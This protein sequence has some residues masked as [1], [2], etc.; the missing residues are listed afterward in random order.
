MVTTNGL[1]HANGTCRDFYRNE[2]STF[3]PT[4]KVVD[5]TIRDGGLMNKWQFSDELVRDL[6]HANVAAGVDYMEIGYLTS[7]SYFKRGD[8]GAWRFCADAD[9]RRIMGNNDTKMKIAAMAD[10]GRV[11]DCDI[12]QKSDCLLDLI[13]VA[14]YD[15]QIDEAIRLA[16]LCVDRGY[17]VSINL[18]AVAKNSLEAIDAC[19]DKVAAECK[20]NYFYIADSFGS[21]YGEQ[22]RLLARRYLR[23]LGPG[24]AAKWPKVIGYHGHNNQ[25]LG[26]ANTVEG[27]IEGIEMID[28]SYLGMGRGSGNTC[29]EQ[30]LCFLHNP[31]YD[32]RPVFAAIEK[33]FNPMRL[34]VDPEWGVSIP[35]LI[36][37]RLAFV[38]CGRARGPASP[39][40]ASRPMPPPRP[41]PSRPAPPGIPPCMLSI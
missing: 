5:C 23:K 20:C 38:V 10:I 14:C 8:V 28:G 19:L 13:R 29:I 26:F 27:V 30:L 22:V 24:S 21:I 3:R 4:I 33:H 41:V 11:D 31:K 17:E 39:W 7:E 15:Y 12:P 9:L 32:P 18:M 6:Y 2:F 1:N 34:A 37:V 25:Q 40:S 16:N 35:Y 36:Q